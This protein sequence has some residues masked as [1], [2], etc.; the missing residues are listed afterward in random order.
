MRWLLID[1]FDPTKSCTFHY[2]S[3]ADNF[4]LGSVFLKSVMSCAIFVGGVKIN[5]TLLLTFMPL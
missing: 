4:T 5:V 1:V 3:T 2:F